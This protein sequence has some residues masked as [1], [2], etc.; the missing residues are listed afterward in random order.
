MQHGEHGGCTDAGTEQDD[1]RIAGSQ[2]KTAARRA[3]LQD[4]ARLYVIVKIRADNPVRLSFDAYPISSGAGHARHRVV[5]EQH[6]AV[7][8]CAHP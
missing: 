5:P 4:I 8:C 2:S 6:W 7:G 3:H 1:R